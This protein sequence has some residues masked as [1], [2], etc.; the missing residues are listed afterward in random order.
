MLP[1]HE[2][3]EGA[4]SRHWTSPARFYEF[5]GLTL[6]IWPQHFKVLTDENEVFRRWSSDKKLVWHCFSV[7]PI[8]F[9]VKKT[10]K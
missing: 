3:A 9:H 1:H 2:Q 8:L 4:P 6:K 7:G 10:A 5:V